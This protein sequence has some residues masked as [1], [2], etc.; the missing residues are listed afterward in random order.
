MTRI[1][2]DNLQNLQFIG[3]AT[4]LDCGCEERFSADLLSILQSLNVQPVLKSLKQFSIAVWTRHYW[5]WK[6]IEKA[7]SSCDVLGVLDHVLSNT[8]TSFEKCSIFINHCPHAYYGHSIDDLPALRSLFPR[9]REREKLSLNCGTVME[10]R[11]AAWATVKYEFPRP[12]N[13]SYKLLQ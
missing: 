3:F 7:L 11:E 13:I 9:L 5:D 4:D 6:D 10:L 12:K 8:S 2:L 1:H